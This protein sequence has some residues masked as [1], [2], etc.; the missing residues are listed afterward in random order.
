M[1]IEEK[2]KKKKN[3]N[4]KNL[5]VLNCPCT[6]CGISSFK[7]VSLQQQQQQ[8]LYIHTYIHTWLQL[9]HITTDFSLKDQQYPTRPFNNFPFF[10][11]FHLSLLSCLLISFINI[12]STQLNSTQ[13]NY[14]TPSYKPNKKPNPHLPPKKKTFNL[15]FLFSI[16]NYFLQIFFFF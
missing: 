15:I 11:P 1:K 5:L 10:F 8:Q 12:N 9:F 13:L 14:Y 16:S 6:F 2:I 7:F 3:V 4:N